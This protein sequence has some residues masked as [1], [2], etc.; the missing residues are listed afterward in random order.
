MANEYHC[1]GHLLLLP[2]LHGH[3]VSVCKAHAPAR[4]RK[5]LEPLHPMELL[6]RML[7]RLE[8]QQQQ[9]HQWPQQEVQQ[10]QQQHHAPKVMGMLQWRGR[11][12]VVA[13]VRCMHSCK[14]TEDDFYYRHIL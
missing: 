6:Q 9:Q 3:V 5:C 11:L 12:L 8:Q 7:D 4:A 2:T 10:Q 1:Q 13:A 14:G